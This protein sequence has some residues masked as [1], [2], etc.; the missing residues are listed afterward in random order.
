MNQR[1][2]A[3]RRGLR[4]AAAPL[5]L[6]LGLA[7]ASGAQALT[8]VARYDS[9][10]T[11]LSNAAQVQ[12]AFD[13]VA[14]DYSSA[15]SNPVT[16]NVGVS[17]G[18]V[19]G[20]ALPSTAVGAST[21][22]LYGYFTYAQVRSDLAASAASNPA[23]TS[24]ATAVKSLPTSAPAG[25][26]RY[27]IPSAEA[28]ALGLISGAQSS[29]DGSIGF[30]GSSLGYDFDPSNGVN[31]GAY[32]F[33][34]VAAHELAEILGR[35]SG[36]N[37]PTPSWRTPYDLYRYSAPGVL[38]YGYNDAAYFSING[39]VTN[40]KSFNNAS[41]G[42]DRS[43]WASTPTYY[44]VSDAFISPGRAYNLSAVDLTSLDV[45]GWGGANLGNSGVSNPT[46][47]AFRLISDPD[48][49]PEPGA[50]ALMIA[51]LAATGLALRRQAA[52]RTA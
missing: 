6:A 36:M 49:V 47:V 37:S 16:V 3:A 18:S 31:A 9:T 20:Q 13:A 30:A 29:L 24:L 51:G 35:V 25:P 43:D 28:K 12:A 22:N 26:S 23:D 32:D 10:V 21:S 8:I 44:D 38:D 52:R 14:R 15:F 48:A 40:L 45:L 33:Q 46:G 4:W 11:S 39:G 42:G 41:Q 34:A 17:W 50:W 7:A 27:V 19:A 2:P 1:L 5:G